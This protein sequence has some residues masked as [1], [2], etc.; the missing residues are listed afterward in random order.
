[1]AI[2]PDRV[3]VLKQE[4]AALGGDGTEDV[5]YTTAI[6]PQEDAIETAGMYLQDAGARDESVWIERNGNDMR[7]R[8]LNNTTP[9]TLTQLRTDYAFRRHFALMGA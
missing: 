8:D 3:Q 4:S 6:A 9:V 7:F 2:G 5:P 1:M